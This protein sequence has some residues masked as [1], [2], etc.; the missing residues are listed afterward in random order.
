[1]KIN[2]EVKEQKFA[3]IRRWEASGITQ[4]QF[5]EQENVSMN[6]FQYWLKRYRKVNEPTRITVRK[7]SKKFIKLN[8]PYK[9]GLSGSLFSEVVLQT[10]TW[11]GFTM[12]WI[13]RS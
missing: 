4:K 12:P 3:M 10:E 5:I 2:P 7:I 11:S 13:F 1:M 6:N 8:A 9:N